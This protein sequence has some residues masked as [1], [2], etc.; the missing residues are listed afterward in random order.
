MYYSPKVTLCI[1]LSSMVV[2]SFFAGEARWQMV[3]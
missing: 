1:M 3:C 2:M